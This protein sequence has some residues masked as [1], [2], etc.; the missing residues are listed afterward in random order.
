M[1]VSLR[2]APDC[3]TLISESVKVIWLIYSMLVSGVQGWFRR[4]RAD[5]NQTLALIH[6]MEEVD[7]HVWQL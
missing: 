2:K 4:G 5:G 1:Q 7:S 3:L 6:M